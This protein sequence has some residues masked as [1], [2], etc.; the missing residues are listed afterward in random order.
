MYK[1]KEQALNTPKNP[2][3]V[4]DD[5]VVSLNYKLT[6]DSEV[7]DSSENDDPIEFLQGHGQIIPGLEK[8]LYGMKIGDE[9]TVTILSA[10]GYGE[11]EKDAFIQVSRS[12]FPADIPAQ[13]GIAIQMQ[14]EHGEILDARIF[15]ITTDTITLDFNHPLAGKTLNFEVSVVDLRD[16]TPEELEHGHVHSDDFEEDEEFEDEEFDDDDFDDDELEDDELEDEEEEEKDD[17][18]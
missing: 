15:E 8:A 13:V 7:V 6:V 1:F 5:I 18:H 11:I 12:E 9:K 16:P 3:V 2:A 10:D 17:H 14:D 4:A